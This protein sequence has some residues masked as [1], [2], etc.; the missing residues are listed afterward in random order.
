MAN[1]SIQQSIQ[2]FPDLIEDA[3]SRASGFR[4]DHNIKNIIIAG[5]G[6]SG[7]GGEL[8]KTYLRGINLRIEVVKEPILPKFADKNTLLIVSSYSGNTEETIAVYRQALR[9]NCKVLGITSNGKLQKLCERNNFPHILMPQGFQPRAALP[10]SFFML[11]RIL[12]NSELIPSQKNYVKETIKVLKKNIYKSIIVDIVERL[13]DKIPLIYASDKFGAVV[14]RWKTQF[15]EN[16]KIPAFCNVL[17]EMNHNEL[18][19]FGKLSKNFQAII[20]KDEKD[21]KIVLKRIKPT[22]ALLKKQGVSSLEISITGSC[23]LAKIFSAIYIGDLASYYLAL[24]YKVNPDEVPIIEGLK[25][26]LKE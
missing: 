25:E 18:Q 3:Y 5:M 17:P 6:G 10:Y 8:L 26:K 11:L 12:E 21:D 4:V 14:K 9:K 19:G 15:N 1:L 20:L 24:K 22:K 7:I 2:Q 23:T 13:K 16:T